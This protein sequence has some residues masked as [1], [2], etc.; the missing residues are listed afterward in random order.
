MTPFRH[1]SQSR[2]GARLA[3][4]VV[5]VI[6]S[7]VT[8]A[9][10]VAW[11]RGRREHWRGTLSG[12]IPVNSA[13]WRDLGSQPGEILYAA[14]GDSAAQGIGASRPAH[15]YVGFLARELRNRTDRTVRVANLSVSGGTVRTAIDIELPLLAA[16]G[17]EPDI[18]TVCIGANDIADFD[19][20]RFDSEIHELFAALPKHAIV[21]DLPSFYFLPGERKVVVANR[22]LRAAAAEAGLE[23]VD[24]HR[25]TKRQGLWGV[26]T[27]F[28]GDL[29]HPNDRGYALWARAFTPAVDRRLDEVLAARD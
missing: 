2:A 11:L 4:A 28:A 3:G 8:V 5:G 19:P 10:W 7:F 22:L 14:I 15:S 16:L 25:I 21:A 13:Y 26:S 27:Q 29:F 18:L 20:V 17:D 12:T 24:L 23:V 9:L 6:G 1:R